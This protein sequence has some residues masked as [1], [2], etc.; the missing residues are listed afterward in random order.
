MRVKVCERDILEKNKTAT[1]RKRRHK[2]RRRQY[3]EEAEDEQEPSSGCRSRIIDR[4][5]LAG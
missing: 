3:Q 5:L 4:G 2:G 1:G